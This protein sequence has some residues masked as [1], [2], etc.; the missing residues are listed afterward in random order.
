MAS[1]TSLVARHG[2]VLLIDSASAVVQAGL[3][4][5]EGGPI[6]QQSDKEAGIAI[7]ACTAAVLA[8][9]GL[10]V[11]DLGCLVFCEGPGSILG[12]RTAAMALRTWRTRE[13]PGPPAYAYRSLELVA[14]D[15]RSS[16]S[17]RPFA[18]VAD[19]RR[20]AWH[21]VEVAD[22]T[23]LGSLR[24]VPRSALAEFGGARFMPDGFRVWS[25]PPGTVSAVPYS[26]V[27]LW[28]RQRDADL[29]R[30]APE[31]DAFLHEDAVYV[32]WTPRIHRAPR[33]SAR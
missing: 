5:R 12:I 33:R 32:P 1:L 15:L 30:P 14:Q 3:W 19:A 29:L 16:K 9:A 17:A 22:G 8:D 6:W 7:F 23:A 21:W 11:T 2:N 13:P 4:R 20:D 28:G 18:V 24:R 31:P 27:A 10:G 25:P 26:L